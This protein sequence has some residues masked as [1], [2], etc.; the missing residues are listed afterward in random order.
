MISFLCY[1]MYNLNGG[2]C[3][4]SDRAVFLTAGGKGDR[5]GQAGLIL[6]L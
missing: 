6:G 3:L 1:L 5:K 2:G 4:F